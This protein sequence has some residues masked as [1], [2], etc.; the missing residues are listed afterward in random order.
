M[1]YPTEV[2]SPLN[3]SEV[4]LSTKHI[5][6]K[7][8]AQMLLFGEPRNFM[9]VNAESIGSNDPNSTGKEIRSSREGKMTRDSQ[10]LNSYLG[11]DMGTAA[12]DRFNISVSFWCTDCDSARIIGNGCSWDTNEGLHA[13]GSVRNTS[14]M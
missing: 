8:V 6:S 7:P 3:S 12:L 2:L 9:G 13:Q 4:T 10:T 14:V 1:R 11:L 5:W